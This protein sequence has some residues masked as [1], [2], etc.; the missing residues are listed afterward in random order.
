LVG[1]G[2]C[3]A[4]SGKLQDIELASSND[5]EIISALLICAEVDDLE[6]LKLI[7]NHQ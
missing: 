7:Y 2:L 1:F 6:W 5:M 3:C 4:V